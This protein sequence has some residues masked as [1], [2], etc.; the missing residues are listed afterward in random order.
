MRIMQR[1]LGALALALVLDLTAS[2]AAQTAAPDA[3][4]AAAELD[5]GELRN[6]RY[7]ELVVVQRSGLSLTATVYNTLG[8]NDCPEDLWTGLTEARV[9]QVF[10]SPDVLLNGPRYWVLDGILADG[11][12]A[13]GRTVTVDGLAMTERATLDLS[14]FDLRQKPYQERRI[15][16]STRWVY[17]A[18]LPMFVL[19]GP[20]GSRYAMQSYAQ[21]VDPALTYDALADLG[22]RLALPG[23]WTYSVSTPDQQLVYPSDGQAVIVQDDLDNTYQKLP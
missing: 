10:S 8:L 9:R 22:S 19:Q 13:A 15:D 7:C 21:I 11:A 12:T 18:G 1:S 4:G 17:D 16:R 5:S 3:E 23:G 2:A 14:L 6:V 20:D